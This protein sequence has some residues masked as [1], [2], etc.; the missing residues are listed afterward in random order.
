MTSL[1]IFN[2]DDNI[3]N[4]TVPQTVITKDIYDK[5]VF[6]GY[7]IVLARGYDPKLNPAQAPTKDGKWAVPPGAKADYDTAKRPFEKEWQNKPT[8]TFDECVK[9]LKRGGWIG[10][11][12]PPNVVA[13]DIDGFNIDE[14]LYTKKIKRFEE[15]IKELGI[16]ERI[17]IHGT[18]NGIHAIFKADKDFS[19][20]VSTPDAITRCGLQVTYRAGRGRSISQLII[21]PSN[22]RTWERWVDTT[23]LAELPDELRPDKNKAH[24]RDVNFNNIEAEK[25]TDVSACNEKKPEETA[26]SLSLDNNKVKLLAAGLNLGKAVIAAYNA[27]QIGGHKDIELALYAWLVLDCKNDPALIENVF[28]PIMNGTN[29]AKRLAD[30]KRLLERADKGEPIIGGGTWFWILKK[31]GLKSLIKICQKYQKLCCSSILPE[32]TLTEEQLKI[33][34]IGYN[35]KRQILLWADGKI[36]AIGLE[37]L[38]REVYHIL[39]GIALEPKEWPDYK[40]SILSIANAKGCVDENQK[41]KDGVWKFGDNVFLISGKDALQISDGVITELTT[42]VIPKTDSDGDNMLLFLKKRLMWLD[43]D[44]FKKV[45]AAEIDG[46][47]LLRTTFKKLYKITSQWCWQTQEMSFYGT[48]AVMLTPMQYFMKWRPLI[49]LGGERDAGKTLFYL[50]VFLGLYGPLTAKLDRTTA[51]SI[52]QTLGNTSMI[53]VLD[54]FEKY[55][56]IPQ[57]LELLKM[58]GYGGTITSGTTSEDAIEY[59]FHH[60][61]WLSST[62]PHTFDA[63]QASRVIKFELIKPEDRC[64]PTIPNDEDMKKLGAEIIAALIKVWPLLDEQ[65]E[66]YHS[67]TNRF[68]GDNRMIKNAAYM[69]AILNLVYE[70]NKEE[71]NF[72]AFLREVIVEDRE[73]I[74]ENILQS[75]IDDPNAEKGFNKITVREALLLSSSVQDKIGPKYG[76]RI[77]VD[78]KEIIWLA[79]QTQL[80][81][82]HLLKDMHDFKNGLIHVEPSLKR[83]PGAKKERIRLECHKNVHKSTCIMIPIDNTSIDRRC[84]HKDILPDYLDNPETPADVGGPVPSERPPYDH[85]MTT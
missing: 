71:I 84:L 22:G 14:A 1:E 37:S 65:Y 34:I 5:Y 47:A 57:I 10:V 17:G 36:H 6:N 67:N 4:K 28:D 21:A 51:H 50:F 39:T 52:A 38:N 85:R 16:T 13:L 66:Y 33:N 20:L 8:K 60:M 12:L 59:R 56:K 48:A 54:E 18:N 23:K 69:A 42:P 30:Y 82:R 44:Y 78:N 7:I 40:T 9:H 25:N 41:I 19:E 81:E 46:L 68:G 76:I 74:L 64:P 70:R 11:I 31:N 24:V 79:I 72:P 26:A 58:C 27:N 49:Y 62:Q 35:S 43:I 63:A 80:V 53:L 83:I 45:F 2:P 15:I 55:N 77:Y 75:H 3:E 73:I 61:A 32:G 29:A